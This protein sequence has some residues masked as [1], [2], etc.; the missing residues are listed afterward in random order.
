MTA[1][2]EDLLQNYDKTERPEF[3]KG[4]CYT[5]YIIYVYKLTWYYYVIYIF[6]QNSFNLKNKNFTLN[7]KLFRKYY[8]IFTAACTTIPKENFQ[9]NWNF[10]P[11]LLLGSFWSKIILH[12]TLFNILKKIN[13][14][15]HSWW[16]S[17]GEEYHCKFSDILNSL[18]I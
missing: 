9:L 10:N 12:A 17:R 1:I 3:S 14:C 15:S 13:C 11:L 2:L 18:R 6:K 8:Q 16:S 5:K 4:K 7:W